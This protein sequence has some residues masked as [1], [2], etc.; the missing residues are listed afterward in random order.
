MSAA[1]RRVLMLLLNLLGVTSES[2]HF[3]SESTHGT[4]RSR[5]DETRNA[6]RNANRN[7]GW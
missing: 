3:I 1:S 7:P 2:T 6:R 5:E 4:A